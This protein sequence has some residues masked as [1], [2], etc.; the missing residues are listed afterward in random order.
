MSYVNLMQSYKTTPFMSANEYNE[1]Y[2]SAN[3]KNNTIN[4]KH[5]CE[6]CDD[7]IYGL[8][9][10]PLEV[11]INETK[12]KGVKNI[13]Q[14]NNVAELDENGKEIIIWC[15][16]F[17]LFQKKYP[18]FNLVKKNANNEEKKYVYTYELDYKKCGSVFR[19]EVKDFEE[20]IDSLSQSSLKSIYDGNVNGSISYYGIDEIKNND[21]VTIIRKEEVKTNK[22]KYLTLWSFIY[23]FLKIPKDSGYDYYLMMWLQWNNICDHGSA[24][25]CAWFK[26]E[27]AN[28]FYDRKL[29]IKKE[30]AIMNWCENF[31]D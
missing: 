27:Q 1:Y 16:D 10:K 8:A 11:Q 31:E 25:R 4:G 28:P 20:F 5:I 23:D 30:N 24:I 18:N 12:N 19:H 17:L 26:D 9:E 13:L 14:C 7:S 29:P 3:K 2:K 6:C 21:L 22:D 15:V